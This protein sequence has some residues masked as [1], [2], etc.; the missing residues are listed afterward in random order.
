MHPQ[1]C[2]RHRHAALGVM[3]NLKFVEKRQLQHFHS[4]YWHSTAAV[5]RFTS[6]LRWVR[7]VSEAVIQQMMGC[8]PMRSVLFVIYCA[9][10][11]WFRKMTSRARGDVVRFLVC[12]SVQ[13]WITVPVSEMSP[14]FSFFFITCELVSRNFALLS[15]GAFRA[16]SH[17]QAQSQ[18]SSVDLSTNK[19]VHLVENFVNVCTVEACKQWRGFTFFFI[20][21][22]LRVTLVRFQRLTLLKIIIKVP[23]LY[24]DLPKINIQLYIYTVYIEFTLNWQINVF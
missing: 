20:M 15:T 24:L 4:R 12:Q 14:F 6:S 19:F 1:V 11:F 3:M 8:H 23:S 9:S 21:S 10:Y 13:N 17:R 22:V 2:A 7:C 5:P 18:K 16:L